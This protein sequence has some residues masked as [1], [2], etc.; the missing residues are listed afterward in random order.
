MVVMMCVKAKT[1]SEH[2]VLYHGDELKVASHMFCLHI[3]PRQETCSQCEPGCCVSTPATADTGQVTSASLARFLTLSNIVNVIVC[4]EHSP[5]G[6]LPV[7][8]T[9]C[10]TTKLVKCAFDIAVLL[11]CCFLNCCCVNW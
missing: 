2:H 4:L 10:Y 7:L 11:L 6:R 1:L 5:C 8:Y 3:H 9:V